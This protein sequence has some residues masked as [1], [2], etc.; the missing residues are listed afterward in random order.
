[1]RK[2]FTRRTLLLLMITALLPAVNQ[3]QV[4][5]SF[6]D[7]NT[8]STAVANAKWIS[9]VTAT[10]GGGTLTHNFTKTENFAG[11]AL[12]ASGNPAVLAGASFA[13]LDLANNGKSLILNV[14]TTGYKD[15]KLTYASNGSA[16]GFSSHSVDYSTDGVN[17]TNIAT[18]TGR[19][20]TTFTLSSVDFSAIAAVN[21]NGNF[22][23]RITVNGATSSSGNNR[24]DNIRVVG[25]AIPAVKTVSISRVNATEGGAAGSVTITFSSA[26]T[27]QTTIGFDYSG[28]ATEGDDYSLA[29]PAGVTNDN[30]NKT[31]TVPVNTTT[32]VISV[33]TANDALFEGTENINFTIDP[34]ASGY[35]PGTTSATVDITDDEVVPFGG[36]YAQDFNSLAATGTNTWADNVT[37]HGWY[38][39]RPNYVAND[40]ASNSGALYSYGS[41]GSGER[42]LGTVGSGSTGTI[43]YALRLKN[44]TG[45]TI[46][47]LQ[48]SYTGEQWR[49]GGSNTPQTVN[50][51]Y[52]TAP[53]LTSVTSGTWTAVPS[54][55]FTGPVNSSSAASLNGNLADNFTNL[56]FN[57]TGLNIPPGNEFMIRWEDIDH[58]GADNGLAI[59]DLVIT[60]QVCATPAAKPTSMVFGNVTENTVEGS[61]SASVPASDRYL[62]IM[63]TA[64]SLTSNPVNGQVYEEGDNVGDG[65]VIGYSTAVNFAASG[66]SGSTTYYFFVFPA[67]ANCIGGPMYNTEDPLTG[68]TTTAAGLPSCTAPAGQATDLLLT[69]ATVNSIQGSFTPTSGDEY[70]VLRSTASTLSQLPV[71]GQ[72]YN[73]GAGIGNATVVQKSAA[74]A[75][76]ANGLSPDTKYYFFVFSLNSQNCVNGPVY[77]V[78]SPLSLDANTLPLP[79]C[80]TPANQPANLSLNS[81]NDKVSGTFNAAAGAD[82]YLVI[83]STSANLSAGPADNT[84]YAAGDNIGGGIVVSSD[85]TTS[86]VANGL[87]QSTTYYFFIFSANKNCIGGTKYLTVAPLTGTASTTATPPNFVYFGT[88]HS[89]SDYSDGNKDRP[90]YT[91]AQDYAYAKDAECLDFLG[92]SEHNHFSSPDNPGNLISNYHQGSTQA[93]DFTAANP[94]FLALYGM[95]WGVISGGGHVVIYGDGMD[96]LFGWESNVGGQPGPNYDVFV[97]KSVYTGPTGLFKTVNDN[98]GTNTFATLAHPNNT[99]YNN[100]S[101]ITYDNVADDAIVGTAVESGPATSTNTNYSNP[102]SPMAYK[103]YYEKLLS[104][105]YHLGPTIDHD[106]HNTT[107]GKT[108][109]SRTAVIAPALTKT[110]IIKA[111]RNMHFYATE[112]CDSKVDFTVNTKIMGSVFADRNAPSISVTLTDPTTSTA[113]A[114]IRVKFG[115][116]GSGVLPITIDSV[117]GSSLNFVHNDLAINGTGYYYIDITN[118]TGEI[119][120]SPIWYTRLCSNTSAVNQVAC[121]TYTWPLNGA[122]YTE[123]GDYTYSYTDPSGCANSD[124]LHLTITHP[125]TGDTTAVSCDNFSWYGNVITETGDYTKVLSGYGGCDS[126]LTLH[127]TIN[128]S[129]TSE[130]SATACDTYTWHGNTYTESGDYTY[131]SVN[132]QGCVHTTTLHLVINHS[133]TAEE[134]AT[135]CDSY[136]WHGNTYTE[137]GDYTYQT[138]NDKGCTHTITLHL[139]VHH[140]S[141]SSE[142]VSECDAYTWHG[143]TYTESGD[144][145]Y[146]SMN[147]ENCVHTTT[148]HLTIRHSTTAEETAVACDS[149]TWHGNTYTASGNY[150]YQTTNAANCRHTITLHLTI[151]PKPVVSIANAWALNQGIAVNTVYNGYTPAAVLP[152]TASAT[153]GSPAYSF[154]WTAGPGLSIVA[155][156]ASQ[157]TVKVSATLSGNYWSTVTVTVTDSKGCSATK[158]INVHVI[159]VRSGNKNDKVTVCHNGNNLSID[160]NAVA[161]HLAHGD[162]LGSC[163]SIITARASGSEQSIM[164]EE[165]TGRFEVRVSPNPSR[166]DFR[167][168]VLG[169]SNEPVTIRLFDITG[170]LIR[171][172]SGLSKNAVLTLGGNL[173][174]GTYLADVSQGANRKKIKLIKLN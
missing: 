57:I 104:K 55:N 49:N 65:S 98:I 4:T 173:V 22:K 39:N 64:S 132:E 139:T 86:F 145:S 33:N 42:A 48:V 12:D 134:T 53:S 3:A 103:W 107:F 108:T 115:I 23:I 97:P 149:Y 94:G 54:L 165:K 69:N 80:T 167:L 117:Y 140:S 116:P 83:R 148:L 11:T 100:L 52:Q 37:L 30:L 96:K 61:F 85:A 152:L 88:L 137:S 143:T 21:N 124:T 19:N 84:N 75:F 113:G 56:S 174:A 161:A 10:T 169:S 160:A 110:E 138:L 46:T 78:T 130:E 154:A 128:H 133:T 13:P 70:V 73:A 40:G 15:I 82:A 122:T 102:G 63:S 24:F 162:A 105:G 144:Y 135:A 67:N 129:S 16:T 62:V 118:T 2:L 50:F 66:L 136:T 171:Q 90:G 14:S 41:N 92:I 71:N 74:T 157:P 31:L 38:S 114:L 121:E 51:T 126:T 156:T 9:P 125:S 34:L 168:Q 58:S 147:N 127:L 35:Q 27:A 6:W 36:Y 101:N 95:E 111:I 153:S 7:F 79:A 8:G 28:T 43:F 93:N 44:T 131:Q 26:T 17:Y 142:T 112:D 68:N 29:L 163:T 166:S 89:H 159:D 20:S 25:T 72:Q 32:V 59:D 5:L 76:T 106:N 60:N 141:S 146:L 158:S 109:R 91:P 172:Y 120:T 81:T 1:M 99:D 151:N 87:S 77:N 170:K 47:N 150:T 123:S 164:F 18:F 155:G 45:A 119:I